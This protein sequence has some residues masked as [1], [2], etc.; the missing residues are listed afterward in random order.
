MDQ[1][2]YWLGFKLLLIAIKVMPD[3][4]TRYWIKYGL[5][6]A[7]AGIEKDLNEMA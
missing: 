6:V 7:G 5:R 2:R 1:F 4:H 3:K